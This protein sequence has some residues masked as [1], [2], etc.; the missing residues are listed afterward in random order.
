MP[1]QEKYFAK[2]EEF[3]VRFR[4]LATEEIRRR[5]SQGSLVKEA[6]VAYREILKERGDLS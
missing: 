1:K 6:A 4:L 5:Q 2:V 3:K